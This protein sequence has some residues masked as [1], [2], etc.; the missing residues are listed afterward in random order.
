MP[1]LGVKIMDP[2]QKHLDKYGYL[3]K[4]SFSM[5]VE[6]GYKQTSRKSFNLDEISDVMYDIFNDVIKSIYLSPKRKP[7]DKDF[8]SIIKKNIANKACDFLDI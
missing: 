3:G 5:E 1:T 6:G 8:R 2:D 7:S 4:L